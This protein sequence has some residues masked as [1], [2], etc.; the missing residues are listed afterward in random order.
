MI[1]SEACE[2]HFLDQFFKSGI[3]ERFG[4]IIQSF[5][6][7]RKIMVRIGDTLSQAYEI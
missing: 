7:N 6:Q 3:R 1:E 4:F 2:Y 5:L